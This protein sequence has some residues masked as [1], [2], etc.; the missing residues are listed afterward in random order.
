MDKRRWFILIATSLMAAATLLWLQGRYEKGD[1]RN[2]LELVQT[3]HSRAGVSIPDLLSYRH[4]Q[5]GIQWS[6]AVENS[7]FQHIRVH[8]VVSGDP[9]QEPTVYAF[10]VDINGPSIHPANDNGQL[11]L[12]LM[13][14]PLPV[15]S[16][17]ASSEPTA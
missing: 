11:L 5:K 15:A 8:A 7:C 14:E 2:A 4:P 9:G 13:D 16:T 17:S 10:A 12:G 1:M 6:T 3:Y